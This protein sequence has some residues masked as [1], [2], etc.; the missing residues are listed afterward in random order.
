MEIGG[1]REVDATEM[2]SAIENCLTYEGD[3]GA[4]PDPEVIQSEEFRLLLGKWMMD[5][6]AFA[7]DATCLSSFSLRSGHPFYPVFWHFA[8]VIE[9]AIGVIVLVGS[10][11]D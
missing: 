1:I 6:E 11:S 10:S 9:A 3:E 8:F 7:N 2:M 5:L 4:G